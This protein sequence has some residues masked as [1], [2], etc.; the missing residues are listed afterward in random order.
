M[1]TKT[2]THS[3]NPLFYIF[4]KGWQYSKGNR[5]AVVLFWSM[6]IVA[7]CIDVFVVPL[8]WARIMNIIQTDGGISDSNIARLMLVLGL[9]VISKIAFWMIHGPARVIERTNAFLIRSNYRR[10]LLSGILK[11]PLEWHSEH[12]SGDTIDRVNKGTQALYDFSEDSFEIIY[13]F[14]KLVGSCGMLIYFFT[15]SLPILALM[16]LLT[17]WTVMRFDRI[18]VPQYIQLNR[19]E[20]KVTEAKFDAISNIMTIIV[21]RVATPVYNGIVEKIMKPFG[22]YKR[23]NVVNELK[24]F[25]TSMCTILTVTLVVGAYFWANI[26]KSETI[27][28]GSIYLLW[29]YLGNIND[30]LNMVAAR[31][32]DIV[33]RKTQIM[34]AEELALDFRD[35]PEIEHTLPEDWKTLS[36]RGLN[37]SYANGKKDG[38]EAPARLCGVNFDISRGERIAIIGKS[39]SGKTTLLKIMRDLF[40]PKSLVL[41]VDGNVICHGFKG[42]AKA[43]ALVPQNPELFTTSVW[44]NI[45]FGVDHDEATVM[46]FS[47]MACFTDV[48]SGLPHGFGSSVK[49]DGMNLSGGEQQRLALAR[50]LLASMVRSILLLDESTSSLD[51]PTEIKVYENIFSEFAGKTIIASIHR[52]HLLR[53]F[54]RILLFDKGRIIADGTF[55]ELLV[56][57]PEFQD[58]WQQYLAHP[59]E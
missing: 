17:C 49:E 52:L 42:I 44:E 59:E 4:Q 16:A 24:W 21:L 56:K 35:L 41:S 18:L 45:T 48:A 20:N 8:A 11:L 47:D 9:M 57:S 37:F 2:N 7:G 25:V 32:S 28:A 40:H 22:L 55:D 30:L 43:I 58:M 38:E 12:H 5:K 46:R 6:F 23:N 36:V 14:V 50:A 10:F 54:D 33:K 34:N 19:A 27:L 3:A 26:G 15:L 31:Y 13:A 29:R 53:R 51:A 39:G 1:K